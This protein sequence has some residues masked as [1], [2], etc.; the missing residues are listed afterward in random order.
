FLS[1]I[2]PNSHSAT[3][4]LFLCF[5]KLRCPR[6]S[7]HMHLFLSFILRALAVLVKDAIF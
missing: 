1:A 7:L 6:N 4:T 2:G 3:F 5:R